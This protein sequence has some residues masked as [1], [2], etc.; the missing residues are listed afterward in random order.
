MALIYHALSDSEYKRLVNKC[1]TAEAA[2]AALASAS[3][4]ELDKHSGNNKNTDYHHH[5]RS[6]AAAASAGVDGRRRS[7]RS[8]SQELGGERGGREADGAAAISS[9]MRNTYPSS[10]NSINEQARNSQLF[11]RLAK[12][13]INLNVKW[14][15]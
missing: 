9:G 14:T 4:H 13:W 3:H 15:Y 5:Q 8:E 7:R 11:K 12:K 10:I 1:Q 6:T 2:A